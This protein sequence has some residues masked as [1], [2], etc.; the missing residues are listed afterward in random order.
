MKI[1][2]AGTKMV[3]LLLL[4]MGLLKPVS[5]EVTFDQV[6]QN[7][8][9]A[10]T[11]A[12][13]HGV[14][15]AQLLAVDEKI[16][17][18]EGREKAFEVYLLSIPRTSPNFLWTNMGGA[19]AQALQDPT[20][21]VMS[22]GVASSVSCRMRAECVRDA[23]IGAALCKRACAG[24]GGGGH[25]G[26]LTCEQQCSLDQSSNRMFCVFNFPCP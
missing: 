22:A 25:T 8:S 11:W 18:S 2:N 20:A 3:A 12:H 24:G 16:G 5:A 1:V 17:N 21:F 10:V 23:S 7:K 6:E 4:F 26:G 15:D 14:T 9:L 13:E 19:V